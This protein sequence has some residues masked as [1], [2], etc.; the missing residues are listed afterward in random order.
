MSGATLLPVSLGWGGSVLAHT[1]FL[2]HDSLDVFTWQLGSEG[3]SE[4]ASPLGPGLRSP[5]K[6]FLNIL[7]V[8]AR[9][10]LRPAQS[11]RVDN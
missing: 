4:T 7:L 3:K 10:D 5:R 6:S 8:K 2:Q 9:Q 11:Q 1:A